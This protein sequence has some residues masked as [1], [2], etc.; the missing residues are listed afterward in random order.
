MDME[1]VYSFPSMYDKTRKA[2]KVAMKQEDFKKTFDAI[3]YRVGNSGEESSISF[4]VDG[5]VYECKIS[6]HYDSD[7]NEHY[8]AITVYSKGSRLQA[9]HLFFN[10]RF[11]YQ[12][13]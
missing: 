7:N 8:L 3:A 12:S 5:S 1:C 13:A 9:N 2:F 10:Y 11:T 4:V 6:R